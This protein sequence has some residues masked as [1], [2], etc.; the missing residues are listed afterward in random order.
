MAVSE[1]E[2]RKQFRR[3]KPVYSPPRAVKDPAELIESWAYLLQDMA[4]ADLDTAVTL[5]MRSEAEWWPKPGQLR[6]LVFTDG[7]RAAAQ[8]EGNAMSN[9]DGSCIVCGA[10]VE[11][12]DANGEPTALDKPGRYHIRHHRAKHDAEGVAVPG[13]FAR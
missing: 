12:L 2:I 9:P 6:A 8:G 1:T 4:D 7:A 5:Y 3:L 13:P 10:P 11:W